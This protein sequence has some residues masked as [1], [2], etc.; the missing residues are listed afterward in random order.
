MNFLYRFLAKGIIKK[1][2][3]NKKIKIIST[4]FVVYVA[5]L[6]AKELKNLGFEPEIEILRKISRRDVFRLRASLCIVLCTNFYKRL[7]PFYIAYQLEQSKSSN[8]FSKKY[9]KQLKGAIAIFDYCLENIDFLVEKGLVR[10]QI[11]Y[12][13]IGF[14]PAYLEYLQETSRIDLSKVIDC[15]MLFY[16]GLNNRRKDIIDNIGDDVGLK[17]VRGKFDKELY[18]ELLGAKVVL[19]IHFESNSLLE[20][21]RI[22][23]CLSLG[24][25]V[26]SEEARN[27]AEYEFLRPY[28]RFVKIGDVEGLLSEARAAILEGKK[29]ITHIIGDEF[30]VRFSSAFQHILN[31]FL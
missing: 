9:L 18:P 12:V 21:T 31:K 1:S 29:N 13:P 16:G 14:F 19:N 24:I 7:P 20:T 27:R 17:C 23:E 30:S 26:V 2:I 3:E 15:D 25:P 8:W 22:F 4:P 28:V 11:Y 10:D 5:D 6:L